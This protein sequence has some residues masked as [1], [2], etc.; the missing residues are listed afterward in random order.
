MVV[1]FRSEN[2]RVWKRFVKYYFSKKKNKS[3]THFIG[4]HFLN[5]MFGSNFISM[6]TVHIKRKDCCEVI[7]ALNY[8]LDGLNDLG[9]WVVAIQHHIFERQ[10]FSDCQFWLF[11]LTVNCTTKFL[12]GMWKEMQL[13]CIT[14]V[15]L[16]VSSSSHLFHC[17]EFYFAARWSV[18]YRGQLYRSWQH[19]ADQW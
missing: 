3:C 13:F 6:S 18:W 11:L 17:N 19:G 2:F 1:I 7:C 8:K 4:Y 15:V 12:R 9:Q 5:V 16:L 14:S 10:T